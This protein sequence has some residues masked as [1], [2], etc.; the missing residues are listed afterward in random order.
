LPEKGTTGLRAAPN[1][2]AGAGGSGVA[3]EDEPSCS[4][5]EGDGHVVG[6]DGQVEF[7]GRG[8]LAEEHMATPA[9][10]DGLLDFRTPGHAVA[11][12]SKQ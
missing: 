7:L 6:T 3:A 1:S 4:T 12:G 8:S 2:Q 11:I 10:S 5:E 9:V